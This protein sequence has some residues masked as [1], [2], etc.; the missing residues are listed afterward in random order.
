MMRR[1]KQRIPVLLLALMMLVGLCTTALAEYN[2]ADGILSVHGVTLS[3]QE[4][5]NAMKEIDPKSD[6]VAYRIQWQSEE[7][8]NEQ[9]VSILRE[10]KFSHETEYNLLKLERSG[11]KFFWNIVASFKAKVYDKLYVNEHKDGVSTQREINVYRDLDAEFTI[12]K[13]EGYT[14]TVRYNDQDITDTGTATEGGVTY[15]LGLDEDASVDVY[16]KQE[17]DSTVVL[18][19][20]DQAAGKALVQAV[21][22]GS[23]TELSEA[24]SSVPQGTAV[25]IKA[26]PAKG[27]YIGSLAVYCAE[28]NDLGETVETLVTDT[29]SYDDDHVAS[30]SFT[31]GTR[32]NYIVKVEPRDAKIVLDNND[33]SIQSI[34]YNELLTQEMVEN[35]LLALIDM[36]KS[37]PVPDRSKGTLEIEY[38]V[39]KSISLGEIW[40]NIG[41]KPILGYHAFGEQG[42]EK[43]RFTYDAQDNRYP[44]TER[45]FSVTLND[46]RIATS[47]AVKE[48]QDKITYRKTP[49]LD[50]IVSAIC[51]GVAESETQAAI[52]GAQVKLTHYVLNGIAIGIDDTNRILDALKLMGIKDSE[53]FRA[54]EHTV[55][56]SY[57]G[58]AER[59][60]PCTADVT[61]TIDRAQASIVVNA[62][63]V[64]FNGKPISSP[65]DVTAAAPNTGDTVAYIQIVAGLGIDGKTFINIDMPDTLGLGGLL[66]DGKTVSLGELSGLLNQILDATDIGSEAMDMICRV[67]DEIAKVEGLGK[68][69]ITLSSGKNIM[70]KDS[71]VYLI[72]GVISDTNYE[73]RA[74]VNYAVIRPRAVEG[75][76]EF[77]FKD[78]NFVVLLSS[79]N[80]YDFGAHINEQGLSGEQIDW[81][82]GRI[83]HLF[84]GAAADGTP[85]IGSTEPTK[86][87]AYTQIAYIADL[88][89]D[90]VYAAPIIRPFVVVTEPV[91]VQFTMAERSFIYD[92]AAHGLDAAA[93]D[94]SG[95]NVTAQGALKVYYRG[96]ETDGEIYQPSTMRPTQS[97]LYNVTATFVSSDGTKAGVATTTMTIRPSDEAKIQVVDKQHIWDGTS[98]SVNSMVTSQP[99]DAGVTIITGSIAATGDFSENGLSAL[100]GTINVDFPPRIDSLLDK[101][102][103]HRELSANDLISAMNSLIKTIGDENDSHLLA[104]ARKLVQKLPGNARLT[105]ADNPAYSDIGLYLVVGAITDPN[106]A[107]DLDAGVLVIAP[108]ITEAEL[109]WNYNDSN[110]IITRP[111]LD[112]MDLNASAYTNAVARNATVDEA[113]TERIRY[114]IVGVDDEGNCVVTNHTGNLPNGVYT[115]I[116]YI[117]ETVGA[118]MT[119]AR[120][121]M[122]TFALVPQSATVNVEDKTV[123]YNGSAH[124]CQVSVSKADGTA[125]S[126]ASL[127]VTYIGLDASSGWYNST[128]APVN[129]G[130]YMVVAEYEEYAGENLKYI[131]GDIGRL[132]I[133][134][135]GVFDIAD[136]TIH[137]YDGTEKLVEILSNP[138]NLPYISVICDGQGNVNVVFPERWN[139]GK[140]K[141]TG[142]QGDMQTMLDWMT[143]IVPMR[144]QETEAYAES[145]RTLRGISLQSLTINGA[146]PIEVGDYRVTCIAFGVN[147][148]IMMDSGLLRIVG[149]TPTPTV[150]P[151]PTPTVDPALID[152]LP[153]TGDNSKLAIWV[154][155]FIFPVL[156]L[157]VLFIRRKDEKN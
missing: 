30:V 107:M 117:P 86:V 6:G 40:K 135:S 24:R 55:R 111:V 116:A 48:P 95:K 59:Y 151:S 147:H 65:I 92:G 144:A 2:Y 11:L 155:L 108:S 112:A 148:G 142:L 122:R 115:Q 120:P 126:S 14:F 64:E 119:L 133:T 68:A 125:V 60:R 104:E 58:D 52:S 98:V 130:T 97:G 88:E 20:A 99:A 85:V 129:V 62:V 44:N 54:G 81:A 35:A 79:L 73:T 118:S 156:G 123:A 16:Y 67:I 137:E 22:D 29:V 25:T 36:G 42:E 139:V 10:Q 127:K 47:I 72:A 103:H 145:I 38:Y 82:N 113:L 78:D 141:Y 71:G 140:A 152:S 63:N 32:K 76:L 56:L 128:A 132:T 53:I 136:E 154:S 138:D 19:N 26:T 45:T 153:Q 3:G 101:V 157:A 100:T 77:N 13:L 23:E 102:I 94:R 69:S 105:F 124:S 7:Q 31:T 37:D 149:P 12:S 146:Y 18:D 15:K 74:A 5:Y 150:E 50:A 34:N 66:G 131:G 39:G 28:L 110:G 33:S 46:S 1:M 75:K 70:P 106:Y 91:N 114:M 80:Q 84:I 87:G 134:P 41:Y 17:T 43:V 61:F 49:D 109:R 83:R 9:D 96:V 21:L 4:T 27:K 90:M 89:N 51:D 93:Y 121:I 8:I 57:A 143:G